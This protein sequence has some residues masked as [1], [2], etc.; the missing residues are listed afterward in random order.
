MTD[1][2]RSTRRGF[3]RSGMVA[4]GAL[5]LG[6]IP[7]RLLA[8]DKVSEDDP[9]AQALGYKH[10]ASDVDTAAFPKRATEAGQDQYCY[11]CSLY[12]GSEG[13]EW[14]PCSIFQNRLVKG[15]GWCNAW[16]AKA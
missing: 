16:V 11:N 15:A 8:Q 3:L 9:T 12:A 13:D 7:V 5:A 4:G 14:A 1:R 10:E 6:A 2:I